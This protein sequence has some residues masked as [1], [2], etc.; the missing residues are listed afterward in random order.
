[1]PIM[2][3]HNGFVPGKPPSPMSDPVTGIFSLSANSKSSL[4]APERITPPPAKMTGFLAFRM[5]FI[6]LSSCCLCGSVCGAYDFMRGAG[7]ILKFILV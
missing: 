4:Y 7:G 1:M 3:S 5:S 2:P 6:A